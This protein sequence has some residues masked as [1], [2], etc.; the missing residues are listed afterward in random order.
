[1]NKG[2]FGSSALIVEMCHGQNEIL[3]GIGNVGG[4]VTDCIEGMAEGREG[5]RKNDVV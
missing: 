3:I 1:M 2:V 5:W 4:E